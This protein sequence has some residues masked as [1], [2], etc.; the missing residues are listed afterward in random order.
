LLFNLTLLVAIFNLPAF[1]SS[2]ADKDEET[3]AGQNKYA[4]FKFVMCFLIGEWFMLDYDENM[5]FYIKEKY[6]ALI[7]IHHYNH[8]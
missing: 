7:R 1:H 3:D 8:P 5:I 2:V 4:D 6:L